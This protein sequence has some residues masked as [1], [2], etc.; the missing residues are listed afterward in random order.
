MKVF[1]VLFALAAFAAGLVA[2]YFWYRA[3]TVEIIPT[4]AK[5]GGS[6]FEPVENKD[7]HWIVGQLEATKESGRLNKIAAILTALATF[8]G[9]VSIAIGMLAS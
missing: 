3:S 2:A 4:Y 9:F 6:G 8:F 5:P 7:A 1:I